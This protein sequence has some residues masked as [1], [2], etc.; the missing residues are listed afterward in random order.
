MPRLHVLVATRKGLFALHGDAARENW[1]IEGPH[2]LGQVVN[3]AVLDPRDGRTVV[4]AV[5][6]GHL[7]HTVFRSED[8]GATWN[9]AARPPSFEKAESGEGETVSHVFWLTPG[10]ASQEGRWYAGTS[11]AGLFRSDDAGRTWEGIAGFNAHPDRRKW[12]GPP[13]DA[14]PDGNTLHSLNVDPF[15]P[16]HLYIGLSAG[17]VFETRDRGDSWTPLNRGVS[18]DFLPDPDS[19]YGHDPHCLRVHPKARDVVY[20]QNHCGIYRLERADNRWTR[21]GDNMPRD[22]G[23]IGFPLVLHPRDPKTAWVFPMDGG[24]VWPRMPI[25]GKPAAY[26]TRDAG[27]SWKRQDK[28]LPA[29]QG[30]F[31]VKRQAMTNDALDPVGLYFGTTGGEVWGSF[32]EGESWRCLHRHLP[33]IYAIEAA[34]VS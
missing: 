19:P 7:G 28:G 13:G 34:L 21:I 1:S 30:W 10:P 4:A 11:P 31:T 29:E 14:P 6:A 22:V 26:V 3:H 15:D 25:G 23:D 12:I 17:G 27:S 2:F 8:R 18:A 24:T 9:E 5:K 16:D 32:D 33:H 20:H